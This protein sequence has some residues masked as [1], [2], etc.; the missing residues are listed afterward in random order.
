LDNIAL[1]FRGQTMEEADQR[2]FAGYFGK[3]G[4]RARPAERRPEG[5]EYDG[6][7]MLITNVRDDTGKAIGSLPDGELWFH[8]D[9]SYTPAP[10]KATILYGIEVSSQGG[11]T[12]VSNMY[13]AYD[14]VPAALKKK[15]AGRRVLH[16]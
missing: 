4:E 3:V 2:R 11:H 7:F 1:V 13:R 15:L 6:R 16:V 5:D 9:M 12:C 10:H 14:N 8:H